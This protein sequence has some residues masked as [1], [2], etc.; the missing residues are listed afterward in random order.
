MP[1]GNWNRAVLVWCVLSSRLCNCLKFFLYPR[2]FEEDGYLTVW[3]D[4]LYKALESHPARSLD[5]ETASIF[6]LGIEYSCPYTW[7]YEEPTYNYI[8]GDHSTCQDTKVERLKN[9]IAKGF[10][11]HWDQ[12]PH[13]LLEQQ[14]GNFAEV[15]SAEFAELPMVI[16]AGT[17]VSASIVR[18]GTDVSWPL[19]PLNVEDGSGSSGD[20]VELGDKTEQICGQRKLLA[21]FCG[22]ASQSTPFREATIESWNKESDIE[23]VLSD[24]GRQWLSR[25]WP[26]AH[27]SKSQYASLMRDSDFSLCTRGD[28][29]ATRRVFESLSFGTIPVILADDWLLPFDEIINWQEI[30]VIVKQHAWTTVPELLRSI[31]ASERCLMRKRGLEIF[32]KYFSDVLGNIEGFFAVMTH[33]EKLKLR[34]SHEL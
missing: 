12:K 34:T 4:S 13:V 24:V 1:P 25:D 18:R 14:N 3:Y 33:R 23:I 27:P 17:S 19:L 28:Q 2:K 30:A 26:T 16:L 7:P 6:F 5:P 31:S 11:S 8:L 9:Y 32:K 20:D 21:A 10:A 15:G 29:L 22:H